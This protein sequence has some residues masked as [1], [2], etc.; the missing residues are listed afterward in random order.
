MNDE[1]VVGF[2]ELTRE[3]SFAAEFQIKLI[4]DSDVDDAQET[5]VL[6][7]ELLLVK[8]LHGDDGRVGHLKVEA[9][10]PVRVQSL[11]DD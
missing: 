2:L 11:F 1:L 9:V 3:E 10:V 7:L 6:F 8:Y 4:R 5:L